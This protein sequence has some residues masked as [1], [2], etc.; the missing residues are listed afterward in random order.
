M[1]RLRGALAS[2]PPLRRAALAA[3]RDIDALSA[4][5]Q[6][7]LRAL[8]DLY[9]AAH[10]RHLKFYGPPLTI[11]PLPFARALAMGN[12]E[13][14][15]FRDKAVFIGVSTVQGSEQ[16]DTVATTYPGAGQRLRM[17]G[18]EIAA[19]TYANLLRN[20]SIRPL[21]PAP[22]L[23]LLLGWG[24]LVGTLAALLPARRAIPAIGL[25][26]AAYS[27]L[28]HQLFVQLDLWLPWL[29]PIGVQ[30]LPALALA[31]VLGWHDA[32]RA[33]RRVAAALD[34]YL[35]RHVAEGLA[36]GIHR[37][38]I[39][40]QVLKAV[41][42][43][44]DGERYTSLAERLAPGELHALLNAHYAVVF[45]P[46]R[47]SG[48]FVSDVIGDACLGLWT[49]AGPG[50]MT[51]ERGRACA[52]AIDILGAV[53]AFN[54]SRTDGGIPIR[55]GLHFGEVYLGDVGAADH[56]EY[57]AV[58]DVVN[59]ATRIEQLNKRLGTRL[60]VSAEV[61]EGLD[62]FALRDLGWFR[63]AGKQTPVRLFELSGRY[64]DRDAE[65]GAFVRDFERALAAMQRGE[66]TDAA[67]RFATLACRR[68]HD[69][70]SRFFADL[71]SR[72]G[73][74]PPLENGHRI[75]PFDAK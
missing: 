1:R 60:L 12:A 14:E 73:E 63:L 41:C 33:K 7:R 26:A 51:R 71:C 10:G 27:L 75:V 16:V 69:G 11:E 49:A 36:A 30:A 38:G 22:L 62:A 55:I 2:D 28:V 37:A 45:K 32:G 3:A 18:V 15:R 67:E 43:A 24:L 31:L 35:P 46:I 29:V 25:L 40:G 52:T 23:A 39:S 19:T 53:E 47:R 70:P 58:G 6:A 9:G 4:A 72:P 13:L 5:D 42:I 34:R 50:P 61:R 44:T 48:G 54:A 64:A 65:G 66:W 68:P 56:F 8:L 59:T 21:A 74:R 57:R 17:S 20:E